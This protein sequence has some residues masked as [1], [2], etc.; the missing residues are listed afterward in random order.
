LRYGPRPDPGRDE[1]ARLEEA[2]ELDTPLATAYY[3][4]EDLR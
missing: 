2:P 1:E 3:L 4:K